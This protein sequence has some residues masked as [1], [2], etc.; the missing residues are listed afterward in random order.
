[1]AIKSKI[2]N[3]KFLL[4]VGR[5]E[6]RKNIA[7]IIK[8]FEILKDKY[9]IPHGLVLAG[10]PG[11]NYENIKFQILNSKFKEEIQELGFV[12]EDEK[13]EL[14]KKADVFIFPTLYEG[15]GI[16]ILEAQSVGCPVVAS[17][18][19]S[20]LEVTSCHSGL[21]SESSE[22]G[23][24]HFDTCS[25]LLIDPSN[26]IEIAEK[27]FAIFSNE[28][29]EKDLIEK[30]LENVKRFNWDKCAMEISVILKGK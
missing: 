6:E 11:H 19:S 2:Q 3:Q 17:N 5:I 29:R 24:A 14:L 10:K 1:M 23:R 7:N 15:F 12:S 9:N 18:N 8:A 28:E 26:S 13:W 30:G 16:P 25:A 20:I 27:I 21:D 22:K 4:F